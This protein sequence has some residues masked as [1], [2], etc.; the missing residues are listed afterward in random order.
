MRVLMF[1]WE[2]PPFNSG[3]LGTAC[4]GLVKSLLEKKVDVCLVLPF[5]CEFKNLKI[6][7]TNQFELQER[8]N[9]KRVD[10]FLYPYITSRE[11]SEKIKKENLKNNYSS[12]L[13]EEVKKYAKKAEIIAKEENFDVI[14]AHDWLTYEA[15]II[16]KEKTNK[17]LVVHVHATEFDRSGGNGINQDVYE[18]EKRGMEYADVVIVVSNFTKE[19][20]IKYYGI[21]SKKIVVIHNAVEFCPEIHYNFPL[22]KQKKIVLFLGRITLQKGP[23]YFV[24]M[25]KVVSDFYKDV[26]FLVV[27]D[28]DMKNYMIEKASE[29][30]VLDKFL[31]AGFLRGEDLIKAYKLSDVYVM[32]SVSEPFGITP[33]EAIVNKTPVVI[34]KQSGVS[35]ILR[36]VMKVDF[37]DIEEMANKIIAILKYP[38]LSQCLSE[39]A[40][41][42]VKKI[43]WDQV[44][45][46]CIEVYNKVIT[47]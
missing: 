20:V 40:Y 36:N 46:K 47:W 1:G 25:S 8:L 9:I 37:W 26:L 30:G 5:P 7:N 14:H 41:K 44:A 34:S 4:Y 16:A 18:I 2:F 27:G 17:P 39:Y 45:E 35:E 42:E 29:L 22:K 13:F 19:K 24:Y 31:F 21:D 28:G 10:C 32:P 43:S 6:I 15:G 38:E 33:L 23:E 3:G 11:Y 12:N